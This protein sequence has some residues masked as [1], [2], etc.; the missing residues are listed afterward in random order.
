MVIIKTLTGHYVTDKQM[1]S[2]IVVSRRRSFAPLN[3][4]WE[5]EVIYSIELWVGG[6]G[7]SLHCVVGGRRRLFTT[8]S[9]WWKEEVIHSIELWLGGGGNSLC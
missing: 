7:Y 2:F 4:W 5:E 9:C 6:G 3:C 1:E 8:S